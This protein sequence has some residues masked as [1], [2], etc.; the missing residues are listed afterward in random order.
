NDD[1]RPRRDGGA[2][3]RR[4][5]TVVRPRWHPRRHRDV[6]VSGQW[7][8][9]PPAGYIPPVASATR[10]SLWGGRGKGDRG[11]WV[12]RGRAADGAHGEPARMSCLG[13]GSVAGAPSAGG[14]RSPS[15]HF[16]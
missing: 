7:C 2:A 4:A 9:P 10:L 12:W 5:V 3:A 15:A 8:R 1:G 13:G 14:G 6:A 11:E 16:P